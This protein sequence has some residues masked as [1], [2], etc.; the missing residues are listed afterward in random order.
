MPR[1]PLGLPSRR[2]WIPMLN[3]VPFGGLTRVNSVLQ[4]P[5]RHFPGLPPPTQAAPPIFVAHQR[6]ALCSFNSTKY[7]S[8]CAAFRMIRK[9]QSR[10]NTL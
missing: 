3:T 7:V 10:M 8:K 5:P 6:V 1:S 4:C 2:G 9:K